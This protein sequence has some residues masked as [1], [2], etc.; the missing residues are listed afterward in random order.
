MTL[1]LPLQHVWPW[2]YDEGED[3]SIFLALQFQLRFMKEFIQDGHAAFH[4][5]EAEV[6][7]AVCTDPSEELEKHLVLPLIRERIVAAAADHY[8]A[9]AENQSADRV[10]LQLPVPFM[11]HS[12]VVCP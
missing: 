12:F 10:R 9:Q 7:N 8:R 2:L 1:S 6:V 11:S 5:L 4:H 3:R